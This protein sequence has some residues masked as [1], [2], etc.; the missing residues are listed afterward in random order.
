MRA[1][2]YLS[3]FGRSCPSRASTMLLGALVLVLLFLVKLRLLA[4][5]I[6]E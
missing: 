6:A 1:K 4:G 3:F 5:Y 2:S